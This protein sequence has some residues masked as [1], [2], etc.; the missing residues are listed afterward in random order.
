MAAAV[1]II[2]SAVNNASREI[3]SVDKD[4][5]NM[6]SRVGAVAA[7][8]LAAG[9]II[10]EAFEFGEAGAQINQTA[11]SF[12]LLLQKVG[13]GPGL[14]DELKIAAGGTI[15]EFDLMSSTA[16]LLAGA[17][18]ELGT[19][20]A[21]ATPQL[22]SIARA[23]NKLN[24]SLGSTEFLFNSLATG[25]KRS[26][27]LIL[28]NLGLVIKVGAANEAMAESL[29]KSVDALT[30]QEKSMAI[31][32]DTMRAGGVL[33]EQVGGNVDSATDSFA[34]L[35]TNIDNAADSLK[36][37]FAPAVAAATDAANKLLFSGAIAEEIALT[38][39]A[40]LDGADSYED[41]A[42]AIITAA[43][44]TG[45][46]GA[47]NAAAAIEILKTSG[48]L[49][50]L[51]PEML[52]V[53]STLEEI[54]LASKAAFD[55]RNVR[56]YNEEILAAA[57]ATD[58]AASAWTMAALVT[59]NLTGET[60]SG[61]DAWTQY[62]TA[63]THSKDVTAEFNE[64]LFATGDGAENFAERSER[65]IGIQEGIRDSAREAAS[66]T[67]SIFEVGA[68]G[69][70]DQL[71]DAMARTAAGGQELDEAL[72]A[73]VQ[74]A[75]EGLDPALVEDFLTDILV[76]AQELEVAL[77]NISE[78][79][80]AQNIADQLGIPLAEA[81][82]LMD[83]IVDGANIIRNLNA[84]WNIAVKFTGDTIPI[85]PGP[86][87]GPIAL[88]GGGDFIVPPGFPNDSFP[89][90]VQSGERVQVT[91]AGEVGRAGNGGG[92]TTMI[93]EAGSI[94]ST[95]MNPADFVGDI[96][97][98]MSRRMEMDNMIGAQDSGISR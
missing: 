66:A 85:A 38:N 80:A 64:V 83:G 22:L 17:Q 91:P 28:D 48:N 49:D 7:G 69:Q 10:K 47:E 52:V 68:A 71:L 62:A 76:D 27:P 81:K 40:I 24:P 58:E 12:E 78:F 72:Q 84:T 59:N 93:F 21:N 96:M 65:L 8:A 88:A 89:M 82:E 16:T 3:K 55:A 73:V 9:V 37:R 20:L 14:F 70:A 11:D 18:G 23:A 4:L 63:M 51:G 41:Y 1:N 79:E 97:A 31:L 98:E 53:A 60:I 42:T 56:L 39:V 25:I 74:A 36:S 13:A 90:R 92:G 34:K 43:V 35:R 5:A 6:V 30:T 15:S 2:I 61:V 26:S 46:F 19:A 87:E 29:G 67:K 33:I 32:N 77:G 50:E 75:E 44:A 94:V 57:T 86:G 95:A 45:R 54:G